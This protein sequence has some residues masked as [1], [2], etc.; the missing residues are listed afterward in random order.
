MKVYKLTKP[1]DYKGLFAESL[2]TDPAIQSNLMFFDAEKTDF[3]FHDDEKRIIYA[4]ALIPNKLIFRKDIQ[5]EPAHV[6]FDAETIKELLIDFNRKGGKPVINLNHSKDPVDGVFIFETWIV[7]DKEADKSFKM[8]FDV[9]VGTMM[10]GYKIDNDSVWEDIKLGKL[11]GLSIEA[12]LFPEEVVTQLKKENMNKKNIIEKI[13]A[14]FADDKTEY[15]SGFFGTSLEV[16]SQ[17]TDSDGKPVGEAEFTYNGNK[18]KTDAE[19]K[20]SEVEAVEEENA[21][22]TELADAQAKITELE[23]EIA[24][25]K[26]QLTTQDEVKMANE[27]AELK[28]Q[29]DLK[30]A[31]EEVVKLTAEVIEAKKIKPIALEV[32]KTYEQMTNAEKVKFNRGK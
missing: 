12:Q 15:S 13:I 30:K 7:D 10:R 22:G 32:E 4:P 8:G 19:G 26:A 2:V 14:L 28:L 24:D 6:Y 16:G 23:T 17:I 29:A 9:P 18:Y 3:I 25:L 1:E 31:N 27:E 21:G 20:I 5:G 11:K